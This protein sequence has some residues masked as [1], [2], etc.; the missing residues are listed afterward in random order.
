MVGL[1]VLAPAVAQAQAETRASR[2][3]GRTIRAVE[4]R[5]GR[6][7]S[8]ET[9][10]FYLFGGDPVERGM[11]LDTTALDQRI[12][13]LWKREL[14]DDI[15]INAVAEDDGGVSLIVSVAERP[16]LSSINYVGIKRI[17]RSDIGERIDR[18]RIQVFENQPLSR[19]AL[20]QLTR[21]IE[22]MY[23]EK[24][25]RFAQVK[26]TLEELSANQ[27]RATFTI[28]E[29]DRVK[30]DDITF[31]GNTL[32]SDWRLRLSM[33]KT[34]QSGL[35]SRVLKKDIY[36]PA[37]LEEDL[38]SVREL[39]RKAGYK[40]I[41]LGRPEIEVVAQNPNAPTIEEQ[42]RRL[43]ITI[44]VEEGLR[45]KLGEITIEGN[46]VFSDELLLRQFERPRGGWLRAKVVDGGL[47]NVNKLYQS[48][49]YIFSEIDSE[50]IE[51]DENVAD[52]KVSVSEKDQFR[53]RRIDF[54][55]NYK[56]KDKVLRRE[57]LFQETGVVNMSAIRNSLL[58]IRQLNYFALDEEE[59]IKFENFDTDDQ[60]V[61]LVLQGEEADRTE[62]QFGGGW[63]EFDGFF[64][65]FAVRT[66]NFRG[67]GETLGVSAQIGRQ[68]DLYDIEYRIPWLFDQPQLLGVRIFRQTFDARV[69][70]DTDF[71]QNFSGGSITY[72]RSLAA[73]QTLNLTYS[74]SDVEEVETVFDTGGDVISRRAEF[75]T[76][77]LRPTW[78]Y[79]TVDSRFE[80]FRG[81]RLQGSVEFAGDFLGGDTNFVKPIASLT[82]FQPISRRPFRSTFGVNFEAGHITS[83]GDI[84]LFAQQRFFLGGENSVRGFRRR[85]IVVYNEDGTV[86]RD[87]DGFPRG[88]ESFLNLNLEYHILAG[89]PFRV[90]A[91]ADAGGVFDGDT[92][93]DFDL[94]RY[95]AGVELRI[96]VPLFGAPLRF[97][98]SSNLDPFPEDQFESFDFN[99][100]VSF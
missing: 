36:N 22:E 14:I 38:D 79:N 28:D 37:N 57:L 34:K 5:G 54:K 55:G 25:Y 30:I 72:G 74:Y 69:L 100:G 39:Y 42:K 18:D 88:G 31:D 96:L 4:Y 13:R 62:L 15:V 35:V 2:Y 99:I 86:A 47:E 16:L 40:D 60:T 82:W 71:E 6:S 21:S 92:S 10:N 68:R 53:I 76:S 17:S 8:A 85:S 63:S 49:G 97:I 1:A 64:G 61:D 80:P 48:I 41:L 19:G 90:V 59:P 32:Y 67:R 26:Y 23:R 94:M 50:L 66:T 87:A 93:I 95:T 98:Y 43:A 9:L 12:A 44:P 24:G 81:L 73:F 65:Q 45:W 46:E 78:T 11:V 51:R 77:S 89:G 75:V 3:D 58:K 91:F 70:A 33:S 27:L 56:T 20:E 84:E 29:G 52:L 7:L 83:F